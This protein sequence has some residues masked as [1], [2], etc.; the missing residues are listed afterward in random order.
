MPAYSKLRDIL[1]ERI[2][3]GVIP[4]DSRLTI[5]EIA[6]EHGVSHMPVREA[7]QWLQGEGLLEIIPNKGARVLRLDAEFIGSVYDTRSVVEG[8][9][10][11]TALANLTE[12]DRSKIERAHAAFLDAAA[13]LDIDTVY[14][15][16]R[17]F[18]LALYSK[19]RNRPGLDIYN[20]YSAL[21]LTLREKFG[22]GV[23][24]V[25]A[26]VDQHD[27]ILSAIRAGS[28][29]KLAEITQLHAQGGKNDLLSRM[30][31]TMQS[32]L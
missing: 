31:M 11:R 8:L 5:A 16:N 19:S 4:A 26:M 29:E 23:G 27:Q 25:N 21:L 13:G 7:L 14:T 10:A 2:I 22:F 32:T 17:E 3:T 15:R 18:H 12:D 30:Q 9:L 1:R 20:K 6:L 24:R 28:A